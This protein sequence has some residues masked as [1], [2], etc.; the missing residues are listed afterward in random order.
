[1][2]LTQLEVVR[3]LLRHQLV[4][5]DSFVDGD[6][7][8]EDASRR[9]RNFKVMSQHAPSYLLKQ[10]ISPD[11][12]AAVANEAAVYELFWS[13]TASDELRRYLPHFYKYDP[14]EN[15]LVLEFLR[16]AK[17]VKEYY[18]YR[19]RFSAVLASAIGSALGTLHSLMWIEGKTSRGMQGLTHG[20]PWVLAL[21]RPVP[22][23]F[24]HVSGA[25]VHIIKI[26]QQFPEFCDLLDDLF[27]EWRIETLI[28]FDLKWD[29][30]LIVES[31]A[32]RHKTGLKIVDWEFAGRGDP[33]WDLGSVFSEYLSFWLLSIPVIGDIPP[34]KL[35]VLARYPLSRMQ[36]AIRSF[37]ES[38]V[39]RMNLDT[40]SSHEW[41]LR[42]VKYAAARL[43]QTAFERMQMAMQPTGN[44]VC[45]LQLSLNILQWPEEAIVHL[46]G[47]PLQGLR[48]L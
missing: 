4:S 22:E 30:W 20:P 38:Y 23:I 16:D 28:H 9:N 11:G 17:D 6:L 41:L 47:I 36:P 1:M 27:K 29:N 10:G 2:M 46:L 32:G 39:R 25:N 15:M 21:H 31:S 37:W 24:W 14:I 34:D 19:K 8:V 44:I 13:D 40:T 5:V 35:F 42:S 26:I 33:C 48:L 3:Y 18:A 7:M 43:V 12:L 45:F